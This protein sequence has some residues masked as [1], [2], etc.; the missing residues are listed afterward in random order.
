MIGYALLP[1]SA[2]VTLTLKRVT[3]NIGEIMR[4]DD[5]LQTFRNNLYRKKMF[6]DAYLISH[7]YG[8]VIVFR[9]YRNGR[10]VLEFSVE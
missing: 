8:H 2:Y 10:K 5:A 1:D 4:H 9:L 6:F 3:L 7:L